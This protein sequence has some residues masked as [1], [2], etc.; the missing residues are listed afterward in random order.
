MKIQACGKLRPKVGTWDPT[1]DR[2]PKPKRSYDEYLIAEC[3]GK[4]L[5]KI[6]LIANKIKLNDGEDAYFFDDNKTPLAG[7]FGIAIIKNGSIIRKYNEGM[8]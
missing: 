6:G 3:L 5:N 4:K 7:S 1:I 2:T 8:Y